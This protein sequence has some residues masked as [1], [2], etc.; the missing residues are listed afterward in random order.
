MKPTMQDTAPFGTKKSLS[1]EYKEQV[2][3]KT[4]RDNPLEAAQ[5]HRGWVH[6]KARKQ[7][8]RLQNERHR[9]EEEKAASSDDAGFWCQRPPACR[10][11]PSSSTPKGDDSTA[12]ISQSEH[13][14]NAEAYPNIPTAPS[15]LLDF[16]TCT[17]F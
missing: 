8:K 5:R 9:K 6:K 7:Q 14:Q 12:P 3:V 15:L 13:R 11:A 16:H 4:N 10:P 1:A 2:E 17:S